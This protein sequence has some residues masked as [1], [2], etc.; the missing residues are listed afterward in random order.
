MWKKQ[1]SRETPPGDSHLGHPETFL[2]VS[3]QPPTPLVFKPSEAHTTYT[4]KT[5]LFCLF[6]TT[7][8]AFLCITH[9]EHPRLWVSNK[10]LNSST[11][12]G[13]PFVNLKFLKLFIYS[14]ILIVLGL[15]CCVWAFSSCRERRLLCKALSLWW[16]LLLQNA[17]SRCTGLRGCKTWI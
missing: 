10:S 2:L 8:S 4:S 17:G 12:K 15:C 16:L 1:R 3:F 6:D 9:A 5:L 7:S 14:F 13:L 11:S